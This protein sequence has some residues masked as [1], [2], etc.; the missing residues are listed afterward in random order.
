MLS[1]TV[2]QAREPVRAPLHTQKSA[3]QSVLHVLSIGLVFKIVWAC[4][5]FIE[6]V[7]PHVIG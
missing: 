6:F 5:I 1:Y 3:L 2:Q 7:P 4:A